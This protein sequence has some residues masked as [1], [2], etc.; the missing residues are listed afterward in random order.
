[1]PHWSDSVKKSPLLWA[2]WGGGGAAL[3]YLLTVIASGWESTSAAMARMSL[4]TLSFALA[5]VLANIM[6]RFWR[7]NGL[8][9]QCTDRVPLWASV[10]IFL[11]GL[12]MAATP[13]RV[14]ETLRGVLLKP[15]GVDFSS[16]V[17]IFVAERLVDLGVIFFFACWGISFLPGLENTLGPQVF[18]FIA[19]AGALIFGSL[20]LIVS[21]RGQALICQVVSRLEAQPPGFF[22]R[23]G[24][25]AGT[26]LQR[27]GLCL[28]IRQLVTGSFLVSIGWLLEVTGIYLLLRALTVPM[29]WF[30]VVGLDAVALLIG[31]LSFLPG[32]VGGYEA[33]M[34]FGMKTLGVEL[35]LAVTS[36][37]LI[38]LCTLW[39]SV[40]LGG[41]AMSAFRFRFRQNHQRAFQD[42]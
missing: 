19:A 29:S 30:Q 15:W 33:A 5:L 28:G 37:I 6:L 16:A 21:R 3:L 34:L 17:A 23:V 27:A 36:T 8:L 4:S 41:I 10:G 25:L 32:G 2:M 35:N 24:V 1:M 31:A 14:G 11:S 22:C 20:L 40:V 42:P 7:W 38:R 12:A 39:F 9:R 26:W 13:G 18:P